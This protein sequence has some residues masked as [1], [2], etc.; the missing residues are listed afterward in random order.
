MKPEDY[1]F[2]VDFVKKHSGLNL[3]GDKA[4]LIESRLLPVAQK[5]SLK[6][7]DELVMRLKVGADRALQVA[8]NEAMATH[9][10]FFFRDAKIFESFRDEL[11][12]QLAQKNKDKR[13]L[14]IWSAA[15]SS[16]Q[17]P[18]T[19][20]MLCK[21]KEALLHGFHIDLIATDLSETILQK[22]KQAHFSQFEVQR[23][24]PIQYLMKYF[25]KLDDCWEVKPEIR[26]MVRYSP[27]NLLEDPKKFGAF[28]IVYCR[29]V[30]IYFDADLKR[31]IV[32]KIKSVLNPGGMIVLGGAETLFGIDD[33]FASHPTIRGYY[34]L[35]DKTTSSVATRSSPSGIGG[36]LGSGL[37][38]VQR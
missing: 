20:A 36:G 8:V 5:F 21:E 1:Q 18:Y 19:L 3:A 13:S 17:E 15:C 7:I 10:S 6:C 37:G 26:Q 30:L 35:K 4:Y 2:L 11:L 29:N 27:F 12:P 22:A 24:L 14:R 25:N 28:D 34:V 16:G 23:G 31:Q 33:D 38:M 9:E 32:S